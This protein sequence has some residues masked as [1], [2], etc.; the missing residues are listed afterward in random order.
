VTEV[1]RGVPRSTEA[2][3]S[4]KLGYDRFHPHPSRSVLNSVSSSLRAVGSRDCATSNG[5]MIVNN[6]LERMRMEAVVA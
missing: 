6:E 5:W 4:I 2:N 3:L 1:S